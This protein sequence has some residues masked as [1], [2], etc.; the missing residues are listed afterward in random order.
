MTPNRQAQKRTA[1]TT[2]RGLNVP[3]GAERLT[4]SCLLDTP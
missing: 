3:S 1:N 2:K 4:P